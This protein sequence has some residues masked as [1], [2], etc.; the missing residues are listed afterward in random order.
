MILVIQVFIVKFPARLYISIT[1]SG[2][3]FPWLQWSTVYGIVYLKNKISM[4]Y[5]KNIIMGQTLSCTSELSLPR[6]TFN[7]YGFH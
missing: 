6:E 1:Y 4:M 5:Q 3:N 7:F 2:D